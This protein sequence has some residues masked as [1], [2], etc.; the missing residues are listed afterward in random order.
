MANPAPLTIDSEP[1]RGDGLVDEDEGENEGRVDQ[2]VLNIATRQC[3]QSLN[4]V[5]RSVCCGS[6]GKRFCT[7]HSEEG[8]FISLDFA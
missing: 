2:Q 4:E 1:A 7:W 8:K 5:N 6:E 3:R